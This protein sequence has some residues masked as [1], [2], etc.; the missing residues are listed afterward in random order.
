MN[1]HLTS[2]Q[3]KKDLMKTKRKRRDSVKGN[4][5][6]QLKKATQPLKITYLIEQVYIKHLCH[7]TLD[8]CSFSLF[9][10]MHLKHLDESMKILC[11]NFHAADIC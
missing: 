4:M 5:F 9:L 8:I 2:S 6:Q 3:V 11:Y 7:L 1:K 10:I